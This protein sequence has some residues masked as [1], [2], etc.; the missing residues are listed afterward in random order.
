MEG[1]VYTPGAGHLPP[2]LAGR[3]DLL[4]Q[5]RLMLS[6]VNSEGRRRAL[7]IVLTGP[8]GVGKTAVLTEFGR[9]AAAQGCATVE[10]QAVSGHGGLIDALLARVQAELASGVGVWQRMRSVLGKI[11]GLTLSVAG[12]GGGVSFTDGAGAQ[13]A[14]EVGLVAQVMADL[15]DAARQDNPGAGLLVT[16]DEL[17]VASPGDLTLLSA[18]LQHL[19]RMHPSAPVVFAATG[20]P[21]MVDVL[22]DAGV[23][24]PDRLYH[25]IKLPLALSHDD[26][27]YAVL[28][29][30]RLKGVAWQSEAVERLVA[31]TT[32]YPAHLQLYADL[33]WSAAPGPAVITA[34]DVEAAI[35]EA[36][37]YVEESSLAPRWERLGDRAREYLAALALL[38]G[39]AAARDVATALG[40]TLTELSWVR[41]ELVKHGDIYAPRYGQVS[42]SVPALAPYVLA[43]YPDTV[44]A[45]GTTP[46]ATLDEMAARIGQ[47]AEL[48][49]DA[50]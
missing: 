37:R 17:Q 34:A 47:P 22:I 48:G 29:P 36:V 50:E 18:V 44:Q 13:P 26:A 49:R 11:G 5:W 24:H 1:S 43:Q 3:D 31:A 2:V 38:G 19:N 12:L 39:Q 42:L 20:L 10:L 33:A 35:P 16:I 23:T 30:A 9:I 4:Q 14:Q 27:A 40:R 25:F 7:D 6:R 32:G 15:A 45:N 46:L 41:Q 21:N 8:R 28:E